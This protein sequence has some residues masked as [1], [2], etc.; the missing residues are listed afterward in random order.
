VTPLLRRLPFIRSK[1]ALTVGFGL[2]LSLMLG[3]TVGGLMRVQAVN[4]SLDGQQVKTDLIASLLNV[5]RQRTEVVYALAAEGGQ[6]RT[7]WAER[8]LQL[9]EL[10]WADVTRK[11]AQ[12]E[13]TQDERT[14]FDAV[15][16]S[17]ERVQAA[18]A[19][20]IE[21]LR[22]GDGRPMRSA[23]LTLQQELQE[24]LTVLMDAKRTASAD[25]V[26]KANR[27][28]RAALIF[29]SAN[30]AGVL[31]F[32]GLIAYVVSRRITRTEAA[33]YREKERAEVTLHSIGDGVV[34]TDGDGLVDY[35]NPIAE[36]LTGWQIAEAKGQ[37]LA[38]VYRVVDDESRQQIAY[39]VGDVST[40]AEA[41]GRPILL[42]HRAG[43]EFAVRD[44]CSPIRDSK[45]EV[46]GM[47]VVFHDVSQLREM[48]QQLSWQA[49]H[50]V[51]TGLANRREFERRLGKLLENAKGEQVH[52]A[53]LYLDLDNFKTVNDTCGHAAG[54]EFLRQLTKVMQS[55]MRASDTLARLGGDEFGALLE[56]CPLDQA[57]RIANAIRDTVR[58]FRFVWQAKSFS[59]GVS[60]G[61]VPLDARSGTTTRVLAA[62]DASCYE[63]KNKGRDRVQVHRPQ[64]RR[65]TQRTG[66]LQMISQI[67]QAF[68]LGNFRLFRQRIIPLR[69]NSPEQPHYEVLVR[70]IDASGN[71]LPPMAFMPAA[72]RYNLLTSVDRWVITTL[73]QFLAEEVRAGRIACDFE[74]VDAGS[75]YAVNLSGASMSDNSFP[76]F[77][78]AL[79][80][81]HTLPRGLLCFE[82]TETTAIANLNKAAELMHE[83]KALGCTFALD[84]FGIGMSS[85][86][87]LKYLPVNFL[88]IDGTFVKDMAVDQMD[89]AIV[90][91]INRIA[92]I[93]GMRTVAEFVED[94]ITLGK[95]R[96]LGVDFAQGFIIAKPESIPA[97]GHGLLSVPDEQ[98]ADEGTTREA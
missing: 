47:I 76:G 71:V 23:V 82:V 14:A 44:S 75:F 80:A 46:V 60:I 16:A 20:S 53:L 38:K 68:E 10:E 43:T 45:G 83:L 88:K 96:G 84:D 26:A 97:V 42:Q 18:L 78:R 74:N 24:R 6:A 21:T 66:E 56:S 7:N 12:T 5:S 29:M 54:D 51:L 73:V 90:E 92:H 36:D 86:A 72:E 32:G 39:H 55:R 70:M 48:E 37:P 40:R 94:E 52:H 1:L 11:L 93:L 77:L 62:A 30:G 50:D 49:T 89:Y 85:F 61:L 65:F 27:E 31:L 33:L 98:A 3:A 8:R 17:E 59:V 34:T 69:E 28:A 25:G 91:A 4:R 19:R 15:I 22:G 57:V 9:L 64:D 87:Y 67:N 35:M 13:M 95:L 2:L 58:D 79:L 41:D 63:A 81:E